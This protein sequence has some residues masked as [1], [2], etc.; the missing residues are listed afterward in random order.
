MASEHLVHFIR[1]GQ[2]A[3]DTPDGVPVDGPLTTLGRRQARR[4][5]NRLREYAVAA[6]YS[7]DLRR[8]RKTASIV[9][10]PLGLSIT[11]LPMLRETIPTHVPGLRIPLAERRAGNERID[12]AVARFLARPPRSGDTVVVGHGNFIRAVVCRILE[13]PVTKW[14]QPVICHCGITSFRFREDGQV[15]LQCY[16]DTGHLP[17]ELRTFI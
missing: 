10:K 16:N 9:A 4:I 5:A 7:S 17:S 6:V 12:A 8:A 1:H 2:F 13:T 15:R 3:V 11:A 14:Q